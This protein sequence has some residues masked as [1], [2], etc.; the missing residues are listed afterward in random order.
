MLAS[1]T[2][3]IVVAAL[4][5]FVF[6]AVYYGAVVGS[7]WHELSG[8]SADAFAPWQP[9]AQIVRNLVVAFALNYV[10]QRTSAAGLWA[11]LQVSL[12]L[13]LGFQAMAIVGSVI[14]E[15]YPVILYCIHA[16]D[17][18]MTVVVM[19]ICLKINLRKPVR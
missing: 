6:S 13:W 10:L 2:V 12:V 3:R 5:A 4:S 9:I 19:T 1:S 7:V 15:R 11:S 14:H 17:A 8:V 18:L 16:F